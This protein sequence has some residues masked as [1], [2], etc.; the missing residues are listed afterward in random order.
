MTDMIKCDMEK[1]EDEWCKNPID[2]KYYY[3]FVLGYDLLQDKFM[4]YH[5]EDA[6]GS[7]PCECDTCFDICLYLAEKFMDS[8][9]YLTMDCSAYD[10]LQEWIETHSKII[11]EV[12]AE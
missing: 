5:G 4:K 7:Y 11:D 1:H 9:E 3:A 8:F 2:D 12:T 10:A 6:G